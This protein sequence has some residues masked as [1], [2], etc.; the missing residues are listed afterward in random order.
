[1]PAPKPDPKPTRK[2][3]QQPRKKALNRQQAEQQLARYNRLLDAW[4]ARTAAAARKID[5]YRKKA[6]YYQNRVA[7]LTA[8]ELAVMEQT[9]RDAEQAAQAIERQTGRPLRSIT[10][11]GD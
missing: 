5:L 8:A 11:G 9:I 4:V 10:L 7:E 6:S 2:K 1:M 3:R